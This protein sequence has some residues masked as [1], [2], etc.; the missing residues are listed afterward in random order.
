M[1]GTRFTSFRAQGLRAIATSAGLFGVLGG[2]LT[3]LGWALDVPW[4][5]DWLR[6]GISMFPNA[7]ICGMLTGTALIVLAWSGHSRMLRSLSRL[8]ALLCALLSGL[9]LYQHLADVNLGIDTAL[10]SRSWGQKASAAPMRMGIPASVSY[11]ILGIAVFLASWNGLARRIASLLAL[12]TVAVVS[13]SLMGYWF[14]ADQL[15]G[16]AHYTAIAF[17]TGL[18]IFVLSVAIIAVIPEYGLAEMLLREDAGGVAAR[19]LLLPIVIIPPV[20]GWLQ[21]IGRQYEI[22]DVAFGTA[23]RTL[24]ETALFFL[25][26]W[27]TVNTISSQASVARQARSALRVLDERFTRFMESV[28]GLAWIKDADGRYVFANESALKA[29]RLSRTE[30]YGRTDADV[31]SPETAATFMTNDRRAMLSGE[32]IQVIEKLEHGDGEHHSLVA[33]FPIEEPGSPRPFVGGIAIDITD[34]IRAEEALKLADRRKDEFLATLAHELRNPLAPIRYAVQLIAQPG[35]DRSTLQYVHGVI[36]RQV[37]HMVRLLEDL[38]D[39][40]RISYGKLELRKERVELSVIVNSA[41]EASR[42]VIQAAG[43]ELIVE[44]PPE[45]VVLEADPVRL[46]QVFSNLLNNASKFTTA[47]G[48]IVFSVRCEDGAVS[49]SV[50]D[51]GIGLTQESLHTIFDMFSQVH[52][53]G[54]QSGLGI[55][56]ALVKGLLDLHGSTIEAASEGPGQGSRFTV[57]IPLPKTPLEI[58]SPDAL[59]VVHVSQTLKIL[60]ID[61]VR[62]IADSISSLLRS[63]GYDAHTAYG[64]D[65]GLAE[66]DAFRPDVI[67]LD[68]G[69][70]GRDGHQVCREIRKQ[71]WG[72]SI[73]IIA[74][75]GWGQ[76]SDRRLSREAGFDE[77]LVKPVDVSKLVDLIE[78]ARGSRAT[79]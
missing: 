73:Y 22:Y 65:E 29:F 42:P 57:R 54:V 12:G 24:C 6:S 35:V 77:H 27:W 17:Q 48:R 19:R 34:R 40:S 10:I 58:A 75:T 61:D 60:V 20:I 2:F 26:L 62:D 25:L 46:A 41:L 56:L 76:E 31:F 50:S 68:I 37:G 18:I 66:A 3:L 38:L 63:M 1:P 7:A 72:G 49:V 8:A 28:P 53:G 5:T 47:R 71:T 45:R 32:G 9:V 14:G 30:L 51:N 78:Q 43:H 23:V 39:M 16:I 64:G 69:M 67:L 4:M 15:F 33:K 74:I 11:L 13:L 59:P 44:M 21:I 52:R 70:P 36:D 79:G 55:G